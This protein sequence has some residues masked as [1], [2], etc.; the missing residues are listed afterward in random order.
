MDSEVR[1][2][3]WLWAVR[4]FKTRSKA[5][6]AC[7]KGLVTLNN[8]PVKPSHTVKPGQVVN[9]KKAPV[10]HSFQVLQITQNR[11]PASLT[12]GFVEDITP[13]EQRKLL[14]V[15]RKMSWFNR[16]KGTGRPTKKERRN[17][18]RFFNP[19]PS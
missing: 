13:P 2:D 4:I 5:A 15:Q 9:V 12:S 17:L 11:M 6:E 19:D 10:I 7:K 14:E 3:K 16:K 18:D 8:R 1:I